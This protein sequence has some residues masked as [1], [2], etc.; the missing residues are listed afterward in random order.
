MSRIPRML[1]AMAAS[2]AA[3][4][5]LCACA[6]SS[7]STPTGPSATAATRTDGAHS[8]HAR[9]AHRTQRPDRPAV[10][11][12]PRLLPAATR[13]GSTNFVPAVSWRDQTAAWVARRPGVVLMSLNQKLLSLHLHS[14]TVDAG[15]SGWHYGPAIAGLERQRLVAAFNGGFKFVTAAGGFESYGRVGYPLSAGLASIVTY[16]DGTT[17]IG[18]WRSG[19]P[20]AGKRVVSVRQNL[21]LLIA[22]GRPAGDTG[23]LL[24]WGATLG[25]VTDPARSAL[26]ITADGRLIWAAGENL[27]V[28]GLVEL[29]LGAHVARAVELDINPEWVAGYLYGHRGGKGPLAP[30]PLLSSQPGVP[31]QFLAPY[32]RDFFTVVAR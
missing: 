2:L 26:G 16:S 27:T 12:Y 18:S 25:G 29:L 13:G 11:P 1:A 32:S 24:C 15:P 30:V 17:N 21:H 8:R 5:P 20:A 19:V 28:Q 23:C 6:A 9:A 7:A 3:G 10:A 14:G 4:I 22:G 31:G